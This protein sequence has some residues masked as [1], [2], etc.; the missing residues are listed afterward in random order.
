[1][2]GEEGIHAKCT[3][4]DLKELS[5]FILQPLVVK[6]L[7]ISFSRQVETVPKESFR[8]FTNLVNLN[9]SKNSIRVVSGGA[10]LNLNHLQRLDLSANQLTKWEGNFTNEL[11]FL[12]YLDITGNRNFVLPT[13]LLKLRRLKEIRGV[14]W[15]KACSNCMLV[16]NYTLE[17]EE[18]NNE[19]INITTA[20]L[21]KGEYLVGK[22]ENCR[23]NKLEVSEEVIKYA[24]HGFFP[25]CLETDL[26]CYESEIRVTPIHRCWDLD[27]KI[28]IAVYF[29]SPIAMIWNFT[30]ILITLTTRV[31]R[32]NV[33]MFLT[34]NMAVSDF[35][36]SLY[37][38]ILV[39][40][41]QM[42]Y[43]DFLKILDNLCNAIGFIW[44]TGQIVS[45]KTSFLLTVERF[46]AIV[47]CMEPSIRITRKLAIIFAALTW[48]L[49][50]AVAILPLA[51]I[52]VYTSNTYCVPIRP[53]RDIPHSYEL[54]I[55]LS[56][57]GIL[58]YFFTVP[59]YV[60]IYFSVKKTSE[61]AGVKRDG[62]LAKRIATLVLSNMLFFFFPIVIA[63]LWLTTNLQQTMSPQSREILTG[64]IPTLLFSFNAF[65]NP[66]LYAF[67]AEKFRKAFKMR[68]DTILLRKP[69]SVS[70]S[71]SY[72]HQ[73][74]SRKRNSTLASTP[75]LT[76]RSSTLGTPPLSAGLGSKLKDN[77]L[78][79][80]RI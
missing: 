35:L 37:T 77:S 29:I 64:V 10:F 55:G 60:K 58:L 51:K 8:N 80:S 62:K 22:K 3:L 28:L 59:F 17:N 32:R 4:S 78:P 75:P 76:K 57:W 69:R 54:S 15:N 40:S 11:P 45:I 39:S 71:N 31:L 68:I 38:V 79:L 12:V 36:L 49:G 67:R 48:C 16:R 70:L 74:S 34:S 72:S 23:V 21:V 41:R 13:D 5:T 46:L 30:V 56:L 25:R 19:N 2:P 65:I 24:K 43:I 63:F 14:T 26:M 53:I 7:E 61:R 42:P 50:V 52:S 47:Y 6:S 27:N 18:R 9:L 66:L 20:E 44:L 1:V 73:V 33:T